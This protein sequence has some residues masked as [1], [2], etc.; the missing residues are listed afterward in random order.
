MNQPANAEQA[1]RAHCAKCFTAIPCILLF[2]LLSS[3]L[4][5]QTTL[6]NRVSTT[7][8]PP[9]TAQVT[10]SRSETQSI[11]TLLRSPAQRDVWA[12]GDDPEPDRDWVNDIVFSAITLA[13]GHKTIL[14]EAGPG[15]GR[16]GQG[17]NGA[18]WIVEFQSSKP[19][20]LATP[21]Q[22]FN[23]WLYS[24][25]HNSQSDYDDIVLGW[26]M[27]AAEAGLS[28]FRFNS[29]SYKPIASAT[30]K[31]DDDGTGTIIP[32]HSTPAH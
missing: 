28:Y 29:S 32:G 27:G 25:Q 22:G 30:L 13:R 11:R 8:T 23:G 18:M 17:A 24:I 3:C 26:H 10:L 14:V 15:C 12:C 16:G 4:P 1:A 21:A 31:L 5:A 9:K 20:L 6:W 19:T 2:I 7:Y